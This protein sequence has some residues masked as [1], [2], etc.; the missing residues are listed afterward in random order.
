MEIDERNAFR[1]VEKQFTTEEAIAEAK[2]CLN[3]K[4]PTCVTGCPIGNHIPDFIHQLS[5]GNVGS[6]MSMASWSILVAVGKVC[7]VPVE[8]RV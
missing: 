3:C 8:I 2:R 4:K 6:A 7:P 5:L 1:V